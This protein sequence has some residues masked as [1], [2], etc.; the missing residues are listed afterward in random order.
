MAYHT[1]YK[2]GSVTNIPSDDTQVL[3]I[4]KSF[5]FVKQDTLIDIKF[6]KQMVR[7][8]KKN[9]RGLRKKDPPI[10]KQAARTIGRN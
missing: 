10:D 9:E 1:P 5:W 6:I 8:A 4:R 3:R 2:E 7:K